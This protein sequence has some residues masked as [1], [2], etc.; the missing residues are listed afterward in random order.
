MGH[1]GPV[2][3]PTLEP[4]ILCYIIGRFGA[5]V[6]SVE[7]REE[8]LVDDIDVIP[9]HPTRRTRRRARD[10]VGRRWLVWGLEPLPE[11]DRLV[12]NQ[13]I[14]IRRVLPLYARAGGA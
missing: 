8:L 1:P 4:A 3:N 6:G 9:V 12:G 2:L 7:L 13:K 11:G 14:N 10:A 5:R